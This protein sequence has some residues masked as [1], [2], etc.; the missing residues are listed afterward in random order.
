[1]ELGMDGTGLGGA[2]DEREERVE[3]GVK[4]ADE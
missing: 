4:T 1:M 3:S 2:V